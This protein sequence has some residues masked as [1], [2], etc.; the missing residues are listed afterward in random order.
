MWLRLLIILGILW[1]LQQW[2]FVTDALVVKTNIL[3]D[4]PVAFSTKLTLSQAPIQD[5]IEPQQAYT[6]QQYQIT[7]LAR[8]QVEAR[9]LSRTNYSSGRE[10]ELSPVDLALGW[11]DMSNPDVLAQ[12]RI[13]QSGRF[14]FW[15][16][17]SFPI[18]RQAIETNS[19]NM[20]LIPATET[21]KK[22]LRQIDEGDTVRLLGYLVNIDASDG[23][24]WH[25]SLTRNDTGNG[26]CELFLVA[27]VEQ[28]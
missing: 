16:V 20:H 18:P 3:A 10:A 8:F 17:D 23:W 28:I 2:F 22:A 12:I 15:S 27:A 4:Y 6:F 1:F 13:R 24:R 19:A 5:N 25:S 14:Y 7:P 26:A 21:V 11:A 9:V